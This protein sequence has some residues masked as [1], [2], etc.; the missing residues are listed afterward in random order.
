MKRRFG[1]AV[2]TCP[3]RTMR[4]AS[5]SRGRHILLSRTNAE[6]PCSAEVAGFGLLEL[7]IVGAVI[8]ILA[9]ICI[10]MIQEALRRTHDTQFCNNL[11][12]LTDGVVGPYAMEHGDYPP[13]EPPGV[14]PPALKD[15]L[16][17]KF[18]WSK[19]TPIGGKWD[20]NRAPE[21]NSVSSECYA[22]LGVYS[23]ERTSIQMAEIDR[24]IDDGDLATGRFRAGTNGYFWCIE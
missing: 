2:G 14:L 16:P 13:D 15:Y 19:P 20:W 9:V 11:R 17:R 24:R 22:S 12:I 1:S 7:T 3:D 23:P 10:P 21:R 6:R 8:G 4:G 5:V 18:D